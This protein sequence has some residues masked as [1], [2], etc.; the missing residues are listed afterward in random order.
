MRKELQFRDLHRTGAVM[1]AR[2][3][4]SVFQIAALAGWKITHTQRIIETYVPLDE[5]M[6]TAAIRAWAAS[7]SA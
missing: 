2:R 1:L 5:H 7:E 3:G 4:V 6:A